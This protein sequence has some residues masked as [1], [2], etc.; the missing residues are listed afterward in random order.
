MLPYRLVPGILVALALCAA[1]LHALPRPAP[2][3]DTLRGRVVDAQRQPLAG[4]EVLLPELDRETRTGEDGRFLLPDLPA[5]RWRVVVRRPGYAPRV[6]AVDARGGESLEVALRAA[7]FAL[8]G[9]TVTATRAPLLELAAPL[10]A[11]AVSPERLRREHGVSLAHVLREIPGVEALST[12]EQVGKPI[13]RGLSGPRVLVLEN[14]LRLEDYSWSDEDAPSIDARLADRVEVVRGPA[15]VLYGSDALGGAVNVVPEPLPDALGRSAFSRGGAE[16]YLSSNNLET[17]MVLRGEG[18]S[19]PAGWRAL[20]VGR[21]AADY[22]TPAGEVPNTGFLALNGSLAGGLR[23]GWGSATLRYSRY[24]GEFR[25]LEAEGPGTA[26][27]GSQ[28][29]E[30]EGGPERKLSDDRL[31]LSATAPVGRL[32]LETKAQWQRHWLAE[33]A[34]EPGGAGV[35]GQESTQFDLLL[36]TLSAD[37]LAHGVAPGTTLGVS[38]LYQLND[39]RG[40]IAL[41]PDATTRG[42]AAFA[43]QE[44]GLG[45]L[46]LLAGARVDAR[47][48]ASDA[49]DE[50]G[51]AAR[52]LD[53]TAYSGS[54]GAVWR[55]GEALSLSANV[56]RAWRAPT[57]FELF[58][59]GPRLGEARYDV[60][61]GDLSPERALEL[62]AGAHLG[63]GAVRVDLSAF[64]NRIDDYLYAAPAAE[65]RDGLRVWRYAQARALLWGG[66]AG[67]EVLPLPL[68][69][70]R[71]T[72]EYVHGDN[73]ELD[74]PLPRVPA[75]RARLE[76]ELRRPR[77]A[78]WARDAYLSAEV[79]AVAKQTRAAPNELAPAGHG[80]LNLG[81]GFTTRALGRDLRVDLRLQNATDAAYR[82]F[83]SRYKE[84]AQDPG[85]SFTLRLGL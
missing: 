48:L 79:V 37:L 40:P 10:P 18:A 7:P 5:G 64:R 76:A 47:R 43:L 73:L 1:P 82:D 80:V 4:A 50:L 13:I 83:L 29:V 55:A 65:Y 46:R 36:N 77:L 12:G 14:G 84:F 8:Q 56:G 53:W 63:G 27:A 85:R 59:N 33:V 25:L 38:G 58:A 30:E 52:S 49:S 42:A 17:G 44:A 3:A 61:R 75:P 62:D 60:G 22:R 35:P 32:S 67:V 19:G 21:R 51:L 54:L 15:S 81:G 28:P 78:A 69:R 74:E 41:V 16:A 26:G 2:P 34:D 31:Q 57:L 9:V 6:V 45:R 20:L 23:G 71:A 24:G 70:L 66:E 39:S 72:G 11:T 68:L